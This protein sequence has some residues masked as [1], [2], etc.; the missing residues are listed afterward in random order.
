VSLRLA[1]ECLEETM[2]SDSFMAIDLS[3]EPPFRI[4]DLTIDPA[5]CKICTACGVVHSTQPKLLLVL[6]LL[7]RKRNTPVSRDALLACCWDRSFVSGD[8]IER[9]IGQLRKLE[10]KLA[11]GSFRIITVIRFGYQLRMEEPAPLLT[12][13]PKVDQ[14]CSLRPLLTA[15]R[16]GNV[17]S[18]I[19]G[20]FASWKAENS[21]G[22]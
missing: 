10:A 20:W 14:G 21:F 15:I 7:H 2:N 9:V 18:A 4:G 5:R 1:Q 17:A 19:T 3:K 22:R 11:Q 16:A 8:A 13:G 6:I 12:K